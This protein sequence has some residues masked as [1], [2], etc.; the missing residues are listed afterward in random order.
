MP[1]AMIQ[2][3]IP[4]KLALQPWLT[5]DAKAVLCNSPLPHWCLPSRSDTCD[6]A[7]ACS[8][9]W[10]I[11]TLGAVLQRFSGMD[12]EGHSVDMATHLLHR[13]LR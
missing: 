13:K 5:Q 8:K 1:L 11:R 10:G 3:S 9:Q 6:D 12:A 7:D 2:V 4:E